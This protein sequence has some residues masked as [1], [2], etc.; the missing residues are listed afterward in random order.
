M[1]SRPLTLRRL[2]CCCL[3]C[4]SVRSTLEADSLESESIK[5]IILPVC[6]RELFASNSYSKSKKDFHVYISK[7]SSMCIHQSSNPPPKK[8]KHTHTHT[9]KPSIF[10]PRSPAVLLSESASPPSS[11]FSNL[12]DHGGARGV[13]RRFRGTERASLMKAHALLLLG[14]SVPEKG[15]IPSDPIHGTGIIYRY[16]HWGCR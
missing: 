13:P 16:L 14:G 12:G 4:A 15:S 8:I 5:R 2:C 7:S 3:R 11:R 1:A 9:Q 6:I 10:A